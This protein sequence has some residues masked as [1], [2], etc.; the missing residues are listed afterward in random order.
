MNKKVILCVDDE[1]LVLTSIKAQ[2]RNGFGQEYAIETA[3]SAEE[4]LEFIDEITKNNEELMVIISDQI[5]PGMKG[6]ELLINIYR[7]YPKTLS[8]MLTGQADADAVGKALNEAN[9]Y[10]YISKP[11]DQTDLIMTVSK[12]IMSYAQERT[13]EMQKTELENLVEQ[14]KE[15]NEK[16]EEK[17]IERTQKIEF[18]KE[19]ITTQ[20]DQIEQQRDLLE[21]Q[22]K[23]ITDSIIYAS[24]IQEAM[25]P[26][27]EI[28]DEK[29]P[30]H[31]ILKLP[32]D[33]VSGDFY[34]FKQIKNLL[35]VAVADC[36][37]HGVPGAFMSALGISLLNEIIN[38]RDVNPPDIILNELRKRIKMSMHQT[39]QKDIAKD[40]M[41]M[42]LCAIDMEALK[43]QYAG[44]YNPLYLVREE[45]GAS[46]FNL[47]VYKGD[48][49][50]VSIHPLD[51]NEFTRNDLQLKEGD[52]LYLFSDGFISQF[53]RE[54]GE[55]FKSQRFKETLLNIQ[56]YPMNAQREILE[57]VL[58]EWKGEREQVDD[59]LVLGMRIGV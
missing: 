22:K 27:E 50:P 28:L 13:I 55:K 25:L 26:P 42:A 33:I 43:L 1:E 30:Q 7:N 53:G 44:A 57:K 23:G 4:A 16:L 18:Q 56:K 36:T 14:L 40:G 10:R 2:L 31:F 11:W 9:L 59:I 41:D 58:M 29:F 49:M 8:I 47:K 37:G 34:W 19:E 46:N 15:Y 38:R 3:I 51:E 17:V 32:K 52:T 39:G 12:A 5:M 21:F 48:P 24:K 6:D 20:R 35:Y 45:N 54:K